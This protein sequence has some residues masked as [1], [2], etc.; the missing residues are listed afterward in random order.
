MPQSIAICEVLVEADIPELLLARDAAGAS[1]LALLAE[2]SANGRFLCVAVSPSRLADLCAGKLDLRR[3]FFESENREAFVGTYDRANDKPTLALEALSDIPTTWL[4]K[5]GFK[6]PLFLPHAEDDV[7][8]EAA[9]LASEA[10]QKRASV[11]VF[12]MRP[13]ESY[14]EPK[15]SSYHL[16]TG[17]RLFQNVI[18]RSYEK[19][20]AL[21]DISLRDLLFSPDGYEIQVLPQFAGGS[22]TIRFESKWNNAD[23]LGSTGVGMAMKRLDDLT[24]HINDPELALPALRDSGGEVVRS[25]QA[26]LRF[27]RDEK[28]PLSYRWADPST[29]SPAKHQIGV[30]AAEKTYDLIASRRELTSTP[31]VL[32]GTFQALSRRADVGEWKLNTGAKVVRGETVD[33]AGNLLAGIIYQTQRYQVVCDE[34]I[35]ESVVS[36]RPKKKLFLKEPPLPIVE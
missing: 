36:G 14:P 20:Y 16:S 27:V 13:P 31:V 19:V 17:I 29:P 9:E 18:R 8:E 4:P 30:D 11:G 22:F 35:D 10:I 34:H 25:Y 6:L 7:S 21:S 15:I 32:T 5:E 12:T 3:A 2:R 24:K 23:L 28:I 26:L 33:G 1:Y